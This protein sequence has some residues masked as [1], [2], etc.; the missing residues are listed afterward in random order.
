MSEQLG[1]TVD[2]SDKETSSMC[3]ERLRNHS[4]PVMLFTGFEDRGLILR[5]VVQDVSPLSV[6]VILKSGPSGILQ[7]R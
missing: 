7:L 5:G 6:C 4:T 3:I 2:N 1:Y